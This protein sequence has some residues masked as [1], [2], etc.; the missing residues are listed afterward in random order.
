MKLGMSTLGSQAAQQGRGAAD[1]NNFLA[2]INKPRRS[3]RKNDPRY[4]VNIRLAPCPTV[5]P[6]NKP[7]A[8]KA[9]GA[10][11]PFLF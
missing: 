6:R 1:C 2:R 10:S 4:A 9:A 7:K 3:I 5:D 11:G 8:D